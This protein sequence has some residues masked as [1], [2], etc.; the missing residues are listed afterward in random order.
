MAKKDDPTV[1]DRVDFPIVGMSC[2]ACA[3]TVQKSL[4]ELRGVESANVNFATNQATVMFQPQLVDP[5]DLISQVKRS[6]YGVGT[7]SVEIPIQGMFC[8]SCVQAIEKALIRE[9]GIVK[10]SVNL[11]S[12]KARVDYIPSLI[13]LPEIKKVIEQTGYKV[14]RLP[15]DGGFEDVEAKIREKEY[16]KLK[17][18]FSVGAILGLIIFIGSMPD[19]F[20]WVPSLLNNFFV[21][22]L[23]HQ[24]DFVSRNVIV[25]NIL[26]NFLHIAW[27][28]HYKL[29]DDFLIFWFDLCL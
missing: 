27:F 4:A 28:L 20:P 3:A 14:L 2:A 19:W 18:K 12:E 26:S 21:H 5:A 13:S 23:R 22:A 9:N 15:E 10:V 25:Q 17:A 24:I 29:V 11:A 8:A 1:S 7:T 16:K 6:G